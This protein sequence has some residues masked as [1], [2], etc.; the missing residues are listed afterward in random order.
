MAFSELF[1]ISSFMPHGMCF[2]WRQDLL[3]LHV[4]SDILIVLAYFS[5]PAAM[6]VLL[7]KRSDLPKPI[8]GLFAAFILLCGITHLANIVV[9][10]YPVYYIEGMFKLATALVSV[11]TAILLWPLIPAAIALPS[12]ASIELRNR[13]IEELNRK[14]QLRIDSLS[15]LAGGVSHDFNN[16][17][18]VIQGNAQLLQD[19]VTEDEDIESIEAITNAASRAADVCTQMLAYSGRGHFILSATDLNDVITNIRL[20][21]DS[22][23]NLTY[24]LSSTVEP[25]NASESQVKQ[26]VND[27][28][29][30][31]MEAIYES[32]QEQGEVV[33][34]TYKTSLTE[35]E[36][37]RAAFPSS[38]EPG[39]VFVLEVKDNGVGMSP[40]IIDRVFEPYY[41]TKFTG[42]GLG[43]AAVQGIVRGH[44]A[45]L[46]ID[47]TRGIGTTIKVAFPVSPASTIRY[48]TP[49]KA[50]P[51]CILVV[52]DEP[53]IL[54]LANAYLSRLGIDVLAT[55]DP[56]EALRLANVHRGKLDAVIVDYLMPHIN[57]SDLL[58][59]IARITEVDAYLTSGYSRG[60]IDDPTL[61]ALLTGFIAKPF[62]FDDFANLFRAPQAEQGSDVNAESDTGKF[63]PA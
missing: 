8:V 29:I 58:S 49:S 9:V 43:M 32:T 57:G 26:L 34:S 24:S 2:L 37:S 22:R 15:T 18:T 14:L 40:Q 46:F 1:D 28:C 62:N 48:R 5:I 47:S 10:W 41:S 63:D 17:L 3:L 38:M 53:E 6:L 4:G 27:L 19:K 13:E 21:A 25:I 61:R 20:P 52:D 45:S 30:N 35:Q 60:E 36:I 44:G 50:R 7:R 16:L 39:D 12:R 51:S 56:Q 55:S 54:S 33:I 42:R 31:A 11:A 23:C 59:Q